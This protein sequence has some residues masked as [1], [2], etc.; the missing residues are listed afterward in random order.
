M[1]SAV[2]PSVRIGLYRLEKWL[3]RFSKAKY[4]ALH[5]RWADGLETSFAEKDLVLFGASWT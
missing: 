2:V 5:L 3:G 4:E 1:V